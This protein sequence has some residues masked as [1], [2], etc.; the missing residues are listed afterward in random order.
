MTKN[1]G[2]RMMH[3]RAFAIKGYKLGSRTNWKWAE[4]NWV[5]RMVGRRPFDELRKHTKGYEVLVHERKVL[6]W[7]HWRQYAVALCFELEHS[8]SIH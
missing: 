6:D 5:Q 7:C 3:E 4:V 2:M 1:T 8:V